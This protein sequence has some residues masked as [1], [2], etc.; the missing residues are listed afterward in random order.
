MTRSNI[1]YDD[2][3]TKPRPRVRLVSGNQLRARLDTGLAI[4]DGCSYRRP[5]STDRVT[6]SRECRTPCVSIHA[7]ATGPCDN[8]NCP[9][10]QI[11]PARAEQ[12]MHQALGSDEGL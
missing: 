3:L 12:L 11:T 5:A 4:H 6:N 8:T 2:R 9:Q 7:A 1:I 10:S